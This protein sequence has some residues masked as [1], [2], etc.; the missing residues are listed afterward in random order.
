MASRSIIRNSAVVIGA[1]VLSALLTA[2][3]GWFI[4]RSGNV[5]M[6][7]EVSKAEQGGQAVAP[8]KA[9]AAFS[10]LER[11]HFRFTWLYVPLMVLT[12]GGFVG[13]LVRGW[14]WQLGVTAAAPLALVFSV[15]VHRVIPGLGIFAAYLAAAAFGAWGS[16]QGRGWLGARRGRRT[17]G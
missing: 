5:R 8:E 7:R 9:D 12:V 3:L 6:L 10:A 1:L 13:L 16:S 4:A 14:A 11:D 15:G 2:A 17:R